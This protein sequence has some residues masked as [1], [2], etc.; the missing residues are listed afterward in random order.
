MS[1]RLCLNASTYSQLP[2]SPISF[3]PGENAVENEL[4]KMCGL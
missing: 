3:L 1:F 4:E 2:W